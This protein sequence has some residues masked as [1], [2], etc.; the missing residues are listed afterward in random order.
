[1][2]PSGIEIGRGTADFDVVCAE[3]QRQLVV[4]QPLFETAFRAAGGY[5]RL[6]ILNPVGDDAWDLIEVKSSTSV[7]DVYLEDV[8]FQAHVC[9]AAGLKIRRCHVLHINSN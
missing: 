6:D 5:A 7:K 3:S 8:A 1:M 2:Y 4:R 9:T